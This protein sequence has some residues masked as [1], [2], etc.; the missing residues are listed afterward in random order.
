MK[1]G[2]ALIERLRAMSNK[3]DA[4]DMFDLRLQRTRSRENRRVA[5]VLLFKIPREPQEA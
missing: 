2:I 1:Y 5:P 4:P 3:P